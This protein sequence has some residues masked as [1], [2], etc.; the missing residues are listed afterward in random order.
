[1][2]GGYRRPSAGARRL[3]VVVAVVETQVDTMAVAVLADMV[4]QLLVTVITVVTVSVVIVTVVVAVAA[5]DLQWGDLA[6]GLQ[7]RV[8]VE[9]EGVGH[10]LI[11]GHDRGVILTA[12]RGRGFEV[13]LE[14]SG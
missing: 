8:V 10:C 14:G 13:P 3:F 12:A 6:V 5:V 7:Q 1:M 11:G 4:V 9:V 2:W